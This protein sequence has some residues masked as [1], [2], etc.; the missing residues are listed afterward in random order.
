MIRPDPS[1]QSNVTPRAQRWVKRTITLLLLLALIVAGIAVYYTQP[2]VAGNVHAGDDAP[3]AVDCDAVRPRRCGVVQALKLYRHPTL[4]LQFGSQTL[5]NDHILRPPSSCPCETRTST[6]RSFAT[7]SPG[8]YRF[9]A[10]TVLL[11]VKDIQV[12]PLQ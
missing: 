11:D 8:L 10:F 12:G 3:I 9:L 2:R 5:V 6:C 1:N 4:L 7:I